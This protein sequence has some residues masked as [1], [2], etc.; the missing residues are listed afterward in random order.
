MGLHYVIIGNGGAGTSALQALR[1]VD[2]DS[3]VTMISR[4]P[5]PAYSPCSLPNLLSGEIDGECV[6]RFD[7]D[8]Y[9]RFNARFLKNTEALRIR[10]RKKTVELANGKHINYDKLLISAGA[11]PITPKGMEGIDLEGVHIMGT[12]DSTLG[13]IDHLE[14]I[15][16]GRDQKEGGGKGGEREK[17]EEE[18]KPTKVV[19]IGGGFMGIETATMLRKRG[20]E[21]T[22]VELLPRILSR[23][24]DPDVSRRVEEIL[25]THGI[26]LI[27]K[28]SVKSIIGDMEEG[29]GKK[30]DEGRGKK[31]DKERDE[32]RGKKGDNERERVEG[33]ALGRVKGVRVGGKKL[34]CD[35]VVVAIGVGTS[36]W[37]PEAGSIPI[38]ESWSIRTCERMPRISTLPVTLPK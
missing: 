30:R 16:E 22:I 15:K 18:M 11:K 32:G 28:K 36:T 12:L 13:I 35:M 5:Y 17:A 29:G 20:A 24:L 34:G 9:E 38:G 2:R 23:M 27:L 19:V 37:L 3:E 31:R 33:V 25:R 14:G 1:E 8:F 21:V 4:E 26:E 7:D 10:T 6:F